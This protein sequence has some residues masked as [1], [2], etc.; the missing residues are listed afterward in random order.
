MFTGLVEEVGKVLDIK[1][2]SKGAVLTVESGFEDVKVG[3]SISVNGACLTVVKVGNKSLSFDVSP[4][5]LKRTNLGLLKRGDYV[6][7]ERALKVGDRLGGHIVQGHVDF[8]APIRSLR[9]LGE[10]YELVVDVPEDSKEFIVEKGSIALDGISLTVNYVKGKSVYIN[11]VPH[12]YNNTNLKFKKAGDLL[13]VELDIIGK[14]VV[15]YLKRN[16]DK[17]DILKEFLRW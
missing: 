14:Y 2:S 16:K 4:E 8:T 15:N 9:F 5:T 1:L 13:N 10:H 7:L 11:I 3:D 12:T 17:E 6:N